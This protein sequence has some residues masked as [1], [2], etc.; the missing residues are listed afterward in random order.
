MK[1]AAPLMLALLLS[2]CAATPRVVGGPPIGLDP[3]LAAGS[4]ITQV[5]VEAAA[6]VLWRYAQT[7]G[8]AADANR[9]EA[10]VEERFRNAVS[11]EMENELRRC[12]TGPRPLEMRVR[13]EDIAYDE[14]FASLWDGKGADHVRALVEI[15][16]PGPAGAILARYPIEAS[17]A[18]GRLVARILS[19]RTDALG[20]AL[21]R[22]TCL[23]AFGRNP[24]GPA[25][26]NSTP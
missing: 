2:A 10:F 21:G 18:S 24:R 22:E 25:I 23:K 6:G 3:Q 7:K 4:R 13:V 14:R 8:E 19:D 11:W 20:E 9:P 1:R 17:A 12:A 16:E 15:A 26:E 5:H